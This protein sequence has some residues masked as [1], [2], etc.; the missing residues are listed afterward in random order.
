MRND[1]T[2]APR[3]HPIS[4]ATRS[5]TVCAATR[6]GCVH[7]TCRQTPLVLN[8][9]SIHRIQPNSEAL[10][11]AHAG[12]VLNSG[13]GASEALA[14]ARGTEAAEQ[15]C[16]CVGM[17]CGRW[18]LGAARSRAWRPPSVHPASWRYCGIWVVLPHPVAPTTTTV[19]LVSMRKRMES[20]ICEKHSQFY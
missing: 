8:A 20:R 19:A 18:G 7:T 15:V 3:R 13:K 16:V 17:S 1:A 4:S 6:R 2:S 5:A 11:Y 9:C 12:R 14:R 10:G